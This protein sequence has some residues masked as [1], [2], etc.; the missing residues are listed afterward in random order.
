MG[1]WG[2]VGF[3][4]PGPDWILGLWLTRGMPQDKPGNCPVPF[5]FVKREVLPVFLMV[6]MGV[7][8]GTG[9]A[10]SAVGKGWPWSQSSGLDFLFHP[11]QDV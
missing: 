6:V 11:L 10:A 8:R 5:T 3:G 2:R 4:V 1:C 9:E 7:K